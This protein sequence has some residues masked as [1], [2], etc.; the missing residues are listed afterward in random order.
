[1]H[2][3]KGAL[4]ARRMAMSFGVAPLKAAWLGVRYL[5]TGSTGRYPIRAFGAK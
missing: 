1:M 5:V 2:R 4:N 3:I